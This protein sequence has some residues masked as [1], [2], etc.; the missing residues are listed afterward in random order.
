MREAVRQ[1]VFAHMDALMAAQIAHAKGL[2]Y[3]VARNRLSG[4]FEKVTGEM[5]EAWQ[6]NPEDMPAIIEVWEKD[7]SIQAFTDLMNRAIDKP[8]DQVKVTGADD[9]PVEH[10]FRW[11]P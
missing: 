6:K 2:S 5:L 1:T 11:Q 7:P 10:V 9:G 3:L 8:A 4:K